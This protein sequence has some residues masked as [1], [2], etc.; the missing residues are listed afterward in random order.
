MELKQKLYWGSPFKPFG[1]KPRRKPKHIDLAVTK[2]VRVG[3]GWEGWGSLHS[4]PVLS[5]ASFDLLLQLGPL[6]SHGYSGEKIEDGQ[7]RRLQ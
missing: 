7:G 1:T 4:L 2:G 6:L 3:R 5:S